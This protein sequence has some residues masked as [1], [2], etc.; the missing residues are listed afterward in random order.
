MRD[1]LHEAV[2]RDGRLLRKDKL[3]FYDYDEDAMV[4]CPECGFT[5]RQGD[6]AEPTM[7]GIEL[8]CAS[9]GKK[10]GF[11]DGNVLHSDTRAA[12]AAGNP[13]AQADLSRVNDR[14]ARL[15]RSEEVKLEHYEQLTD[16]EGDKIRIDYDM[17]EVDGESWTVLRNEGKEIW[18]E[19]AFY[20]GL[21]RFKQIFSKL[22][23]KYGRRLASV[24]PT[25]EAWTYVIGE[26]SGASA[27]VAEL[28]ARLTRLHPS[29]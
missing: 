23:M 6:G 1:S 15:K 4:T 20:D 3:S 28:N 22:Q 24:E 9:C 26:E 8:R 27:K 2:D 18:R 17:E 10:F 7:T 25:N 13:R 21:W 12:A 29:H 19:I 16:L 11:I 14:E 5:G